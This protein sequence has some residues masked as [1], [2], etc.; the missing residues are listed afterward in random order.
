M[1]DVAR[2]AGVSAQTVSRVANGSGQVKPETR[3][4]VEAAMDKLGYRPNFAARALKRGRFKAIGVVMFDILATGNI[5]TLEGITRAAKEQGYAV[6][7]TMMEDGGESLAAAVDRMKTLPV[8]GI[9]VDLEKMVPDVRTYMPPSDLPLTVITSAKADYMNTIDEDQYGCSRMVVEYFLERGHTNVYFVSGPTNSVASEIR[10]AGWRDTLAAHGIVAPP[11]ILGDWNADSGYAAGL[12]LA[13]KDDCTAIYAGNDAMANGIMKALE[14][15][16]VRVPDDKSI[17]GVDNSLQSMVA[18]LALTSVS[19]DFSAV[20]HK[21][22][23]M[24]VDAIEGAK[25]TTPTHTLIPGAIVERSSV[26]DL[27]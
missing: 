12:E 18:K 10:K 4:V 7:L 19:M 24:T 5:L 25:N 9:I 1:Q 26:A 17:I 6:T 13:K 20:G 21:A 22:F 27:R 2:A 8:D 15:S 16:G 3:S 14:D 11:P 23:E